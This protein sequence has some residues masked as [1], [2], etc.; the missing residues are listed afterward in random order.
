[1]TMMKNGELPR[2]TAHCQCGCEFKNFGKC[3]SDEACAAQAVKESQ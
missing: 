3:L 2:C 1:M